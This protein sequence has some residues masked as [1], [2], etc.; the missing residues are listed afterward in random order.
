MERTVTICGTGCFSG[1]PDSVRVSFRMVSRNRDY[2]EAMKLSAIR[3]KNLAEALAKVGFDEKDLKTSDF[4]VRTENKEQERYGCK[5]YVFDC[6][7]IAQSL[8]LSFDMDHKRLGAVLG[9]IS[10]SCSDPSLSVSFFVKDQNAVT[11]A[12]L[13]S[14]SK[15][16][17][18]AAEVLCESQGVGLGE[19]V[20]ISYD[21]SELDVYSGTRYSP[22]VEVCGEGMPEIN[23]QDVKV[24]DTVRFVWRIV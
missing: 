3:Q 9:V 23:P 14:A 11:R 4:S 2:A 7:A 20:S 21:W 18:Q 16:A 5:K 8:S 10:E 1:A 17:R 22:N 15:D 19:L 24:S 12:I 13:S 6:Y